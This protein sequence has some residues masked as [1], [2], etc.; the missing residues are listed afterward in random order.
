MGR[1]ADGS[2]LTASSFLTA[3]NRAA[4]HSLLY[5]RKGSIT[6]RARYQNIA[7]SDANGINFLWFRPA[8]L[9]PSPLAPYPSGWPS[10][11]NVDFE[12]SR[13]VA[14]A[15]PYLVA[16]SSADA[17]GNVLILIDDLSGM[18]ANLDTGNKI[19]L[20]TTPDLNN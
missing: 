6:G 2:P 7:S 20:V 12:A 5:G 4:F 13:L 9:P 10:G 19:N 14:K 15:T 3:E 8:Q 1:L 16:L 17:D 18:S 11:I